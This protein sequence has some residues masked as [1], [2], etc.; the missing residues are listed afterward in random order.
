M[1][2]RGYGKGRAIS[3]EIYQLGLQIDRPNRTKIAGIYKFK[4][5]S[6]SSSTYTNI[7]SKRHPDILDIV[8]LKVISVNITQIVLSE[9]DSDRNPVK[10]ISSTTTSVYVTPRKKLINGKP[11]WNKFSN[12]IIE[13][14]QTLNKINSK[15]TADQTEI[16]LTD[17]IT[18]LPKTRLKLHK[19]VQ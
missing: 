11:N 13:N 3:F 14:L 19:N 10:I 17:T 1:T 4:L 2:I 8:P 12:F 7:F 6:Y 9:L 18:M 5:G 16:H 15:A